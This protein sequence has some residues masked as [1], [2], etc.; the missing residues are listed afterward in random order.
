MQNKI[1]ASHY[2]IPESNLVVTY[3]AVNQNFRK[4]NEEE[5]N[6][7]DF[8]ISLILQVIELFSA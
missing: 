8:V 5:L 2:H 1:I 7:S 6:E 3:N 4:L